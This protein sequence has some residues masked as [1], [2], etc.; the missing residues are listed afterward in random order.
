MNEKY[1]TSLLQFTNTPI[2]NFSIHDD[3]ILGNVQNYLSFISE[4]I[5][6][7]TGGLSLHSDFQRRGA[8]I[9]SIA[10]K[11]FIFLIK[12]LKFLRLIGNV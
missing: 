5:L 7:Y 8:F 9:F 1:Y 3:D 10:L 12:K 11:F 4:T 2:L 6:N